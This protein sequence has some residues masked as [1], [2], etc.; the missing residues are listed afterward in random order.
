MRRKSKSPKIIALIGLIG[1]CIF[2]IFGSEIKK[3]VDEKVFESTYQFFLI[4]IIGGGVSLIF[5]SY[6]R[7]LESKEREAE[8][9]REEK[10]KRQEIQRSL[11]ARL[12]VAFNDVKKVR[13]LLR[14]EAVQG[15][16]NDKSEVVIREQ[17][18]KQMNALID[19]QLSIDFA[20]R[21]IKYEPDLFQDSTLVGKLKKANK[22]LRNIID[23]Y[24]KCYR[25]FSDESTIIRIYGLPG[26][27][28]FIRPYDESEKIKQDFWNPFYEAFD[29]IG[30]ILQS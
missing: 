24:E 11:R 22:Y 8:R 25:R 30:K 28:D 27:Y 29:I 21:V 10:E 19:A 26:L 1:V 3:F 16:P 14:A 23:E 12:I 6:R 18:R 9:Q 2:L 15:K 17:Y 7:D 5:E 20:Y 4:T 13:R